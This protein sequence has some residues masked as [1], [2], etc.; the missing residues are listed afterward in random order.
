MLDSSG[1]FYPNRFARLF[2]L[3]MK[4]VMGEASLHTVLTMSGLSQFIQSPPP[5]TMVRE[6]DFAHLSA[7][8]QQLEVLFGAR[9]GRS[10]ALRVG[11]EMFAIGLNRFGAFA[12]MNDPAY[13][14]LPLDNRA[15]IGIQTLAAVFSNFS[16]QTSTV[17]ITP[18]AYLFE[19]ATSPMAWGRTAERPVCHAIVGILQEGL[20][21]STNGQEFHVQEI[22][23]HASGGEICVFKINKNP[24]GGTKR[25]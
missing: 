19:V 1:L 3:A 25:G 14:A 12:G 7:I 16:D 9:G 24:I 21:W 22:E 5:D 2:L 15:T 17:K 11:R 10:M 18:D 20:N 13:I 4:T 8:S 6:F 23:C